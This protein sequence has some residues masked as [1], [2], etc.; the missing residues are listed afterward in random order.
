MKAGFERVLINLAAVAAM[1]M[2]SI[3]FLNGLF[4]PAASTGS[5]IAPSGQVQKTDQPSPP[6]ALNGT[7]KLN[8]DKSDDADEKL[9]GRPPQQDISN[10]AGSVP[11]GSQGASS[12]GRRS[13]GNGVPYG[14][15][16]GAGPL[17]GPLPIGEDAKAHQKML[18]LL[19]PSTLL[20]VEVKEGVFDFTD[21]NNRK[22]AFFTD[23]RKLQ[24]SKDDTYKE[25]A[26]LWSVGRLSFDEKGPRGEKIT[27]TFQLE[28]NARQLI[29]KTEVDSSKIYSPVVIRYIY[30][31][32]PN[33]K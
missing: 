22:R 18:D 1:G 3:G 11:S 23:G 20:T 17:G 6:Q 12:G 2:V 30:D 10:D 16:G 9:R 26:A 21:E 5:Q 31:V 27:V 29:E 25:I 33:G 8:A 4:N 32:V 24:K 28:R 19:R 14:R 13:G 7:W 15:P